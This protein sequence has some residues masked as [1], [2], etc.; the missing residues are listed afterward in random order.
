MG[1]GPDGLLM[2]QAGDVARYTISKMLPLVLAAA[3]AAW[4]KRRE[5]IRR[6]FAEL[7]ELR[8]AQ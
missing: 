2:S 5:R 7:D 8:K 6:M 1:N 3:L 4:L